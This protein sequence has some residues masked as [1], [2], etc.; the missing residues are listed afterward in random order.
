MNKSFEE[1]KKIYKNTEFVGLFKEII[2]LFEIKTYVELGVRKAYTFNQ[3]APLVSKAIAVDID[4]MEN[5]I[6]LSNVQKIIMN[7]NELAKI[8]KEPIDFLFIDACHEKEQVLKDFD[9]FSKFVKEGTGI[10]T[11]HDTHPIDERLLSEQNCW[12][13]WEAAWEIRKNPKY[14]DFEIFTLPGPFAGLSLIR[15]SKN[16][17]SWRN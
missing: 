1:L 16:Q 9:N 14:S 6:M 5:V 11:I 17:L 8:W 15:K 2:K 7:T 4:S 10:I 12:N 13:S 3:I